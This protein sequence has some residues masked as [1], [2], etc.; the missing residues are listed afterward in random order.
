MS[1]NAIKN[2]PITNSRL[3]KTV[4]DKWVLY[5]NIPDAMK[6]LKN[7]ETT[8]KNLINMDA[9]QMTVKSVTVPSVQVKAIS[10]QYG[11]DNFHISSHSRAPYELLSI[12]FDITN[13]FAN[14]ATFYEWLNLILDEK[15]AI[16]D[17][18]NKINKNNIF[19][20]DSY[21]TNLGLLGCDEYNNVK[22]KFAFTMAFPTKVKGFTF[23]YTQDTVISS[24]VEFAFSQMYVEYPKDL[25]IK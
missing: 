17:A 8:G 23:D 18:H 12:N 13:D 21:W 3:N 5:F 10:Q 4:I 7:D 11:A 14:W 1:D 6:M 15:Y 19:K 9:V 2:L 16:P 22:I 25:S 20:S 24:G